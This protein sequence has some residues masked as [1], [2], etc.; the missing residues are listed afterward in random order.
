MN[1]LA[2]PPH[3]WVMCKKAH[4]GWNGGVTPGT[5][6]LYRVSV[7]GKNPRF[8]VMTADEH[9][10]I[11]ALSLTKMRQHFTPLKDKEPVPVTVSFKEAL[12]LYPA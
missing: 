8:C 6:Y 7:T 4:P 9:R 2:S 11:V 5:E 12:R 1:A 10:H 3:K